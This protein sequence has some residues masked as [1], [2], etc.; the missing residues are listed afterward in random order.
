MGENS[1]AGFSF[2]LD[3]IEFDRIKAMFYF[4]I[5]DETELRLLD[6]QQT[7]K[8]FELT[9]Q[10]R[11]H[12]REWLPW[13]DSNLS[14]E[15]TARFIRSTLD[16][17]AQNYGFQAGIWH[18]GHLAGVIGFHRIEWANRRTSIGYWVGK[19]YQGKGLVTK[20]C[21]ALIDYAFNELRLN[22]IEI[23]CATGNKKSCDIPERLGFTKEGVIRQ[24]E[25]LYDHFVDHNVYGILAS[26]WKKPTTTKKEARSL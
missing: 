6:L 1:I 16:Q 24:A 7:E 12:L 26:E 17:L 13:V 20:A 10:N 25:W 11:S 19:E 4:K 5:D 2:A 18:R 15:E 14:Y 9:E 23:R 8:L 22:R 3:S 21:I